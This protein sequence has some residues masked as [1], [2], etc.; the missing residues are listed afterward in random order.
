MS[1]VVISSVTKDNKFDVAQTSY[2]ETRIELG[3]GKQEANQLAR[4]M[5]LGGGFGDNP[6]PPFFAKAA[7]SWLL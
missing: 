4:K 5:N 2:H 7:V 6:V 1:Y 3:V